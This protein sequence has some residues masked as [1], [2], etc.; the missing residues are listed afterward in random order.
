MPARA[1]RLD[2]DRDRDGRGTEPGL[3][4]NGLEHDAA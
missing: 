1:A 3:L 4:V 2:G